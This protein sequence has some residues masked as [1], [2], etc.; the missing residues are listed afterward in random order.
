MLM[1][2]FPQKSKGNKKWLW[3]VLGAIIAI[4][5]IVAAV[6]GGVLGSRAASDNNTSSSSADS[7]SNNA[8]AGGAT[9]TV[10]LFF[11]CACASSHG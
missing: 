11:P 8:D 9:P 5:I 7:N 2:P 1:A 3:I 4:C 10:S 6:V